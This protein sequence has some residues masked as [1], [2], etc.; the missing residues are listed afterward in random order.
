MPIELVMNI[1]QSTRATAV[2]TATEEAVIKLGLQHVYK[3]T[4]QTE[5]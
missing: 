5:Q 4:W 1:H 3:W 2:A